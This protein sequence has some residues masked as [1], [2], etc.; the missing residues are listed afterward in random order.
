MA[1]VTRR[2]PWLSPLRLLLVPW[3]SSFW[4]YQPLCVWHYKSVTTDRSLSI[5]QLGNDLVNDSKPL[6][7]RRKSVRRSSAG[8]YPE[9][10]NRRPR[11]WQ[12]DCPVPVREVS[13]YPF[14]NSPPSPSGLP[15]GK[16]LA[17]LRTLW[18]G[19]LTLPRMAYQNVLFDTPKLW[20]VKLR[21][22]SPP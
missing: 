22:Y 6:G 16:W 7:F 3:F 17:I 15:N 21:N 10:L 20:Y 14:T 12:P 13:Y 11:S 2:P 1:W 8:L 5:H 9:F 4:P 19:N 18:R